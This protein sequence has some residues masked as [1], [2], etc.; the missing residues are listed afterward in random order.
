MGFTEPDSPP[1]RPG[2]RAA[3]PRSGAAPAPYYGGAISPIDAHGDPDPGGRD[4]AS[5]SVPG[6]MSMAAARLGE[7]ESDISGAAGG[8]LGDLMALPPSPLDPGVGSLGVTDPS[9]GFFDPPR[10]Y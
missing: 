2:Q 9:G 8:V 1:E 7:L 4:I 10:N 6:S 3:E 5:D